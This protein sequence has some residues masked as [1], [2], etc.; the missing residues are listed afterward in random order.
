MHAHTHVHTAK[1]WPV[2]GGMCCHNIE[3]KTS[4]SPAQ[5]GKGTQSH[6]AG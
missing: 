3:P 1:L 6:T 2:I 4:I 5:I